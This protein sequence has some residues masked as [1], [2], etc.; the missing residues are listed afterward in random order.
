MLNI[1]TIL[2]I[3]FLSKLFNI[4]RLLLHKNPYNKIRR[5]FYTNVLL[6]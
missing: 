4:E 3:L 6:C 1:I 5:K 2:T